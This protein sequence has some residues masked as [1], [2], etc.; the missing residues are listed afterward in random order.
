MGG[1]GCFVVVIYIFAAYPFNILK[2][3]WSFL[4]AG[5]IFRA[6]IRVISVLQ[7]GDVYQCDLYALGWAEFLSDLTMGV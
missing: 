7:R 1:N 3:T 4:G 5:A 2:W 6:P